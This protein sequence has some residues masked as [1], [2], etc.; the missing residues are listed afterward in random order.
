MLSQYSYESGSHTF[1]FL[2]INKAVSIMYIKCI[3]KLLHTHCT[4]QN[5]LQRIQSQLE[6]KH[7]KHQKHSACC[8]VTFNYRSREPV[9]NRLRINTVCFRQNVLTNTGIRFLSIIKQYLTDSCTKTTGRL[10]LLALTCSRNTCRWIFLSSALLMY[11]G[12]KSKPI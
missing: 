11:L 8:V 1:Q 4:I 7:E 9:F 6:I 10:C 12:V 2:L 3:Y 5:R